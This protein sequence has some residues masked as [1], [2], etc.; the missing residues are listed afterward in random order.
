[1]LGQDE[2]TKYL[3][4]TRRPGGA[5]GDTVAEPEQQRLRAAGYFPDLWHWRAHR[6]N[7]VGFAVDQLVGPGGWATPAAPPTPPIGT[8]PTAA[9]A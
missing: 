5:F 6:S 1:M 3:P 7:P 4:A 9:H 8:A 2:A